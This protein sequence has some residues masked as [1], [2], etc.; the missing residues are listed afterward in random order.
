MRYHSYI[1]MTY[2]R[3]LRSR[4]ELAHTELSTLREHS[5]RRT[6]IESLNLADIKS[7]N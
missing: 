2:A 1:T 4:H 7:Q 6:Y 3:N 5:N